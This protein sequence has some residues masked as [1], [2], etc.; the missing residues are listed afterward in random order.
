MWRG[1][2]RVHDLIDV[3]ELALL[4]DQCTT[5]QALAFGSIKPEFLNG[6]GPVHVVKKDVLAKASPGVV[7]RS[8]KHL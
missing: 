4:I 1:E 8:H 2:A 6:G 3:H 5:Q 7:A